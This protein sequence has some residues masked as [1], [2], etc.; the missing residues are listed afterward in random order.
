MLTW[1][2]QKE[3]MGRP[4][5]LSDCHPIV[6]R[7]HEIVLLYDLA[8]VRQWNCWMTDTRL[9]ITSQTTMA[10]LQNIFTCSALVQVMTFAL[11]Q[12]WGSW[13]HPKIGDPRIFCGFLQEMTRTPSCTIREIPTGNVSDS[14]PRCKTWM[15][16]H[17]LCCLRCPKFWTT[18]APTF[19]KLRRFTK[20]AMISYDFCW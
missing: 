2:Q 5:F 17:K 18:K 6:I 12:T 14:D 1:W 10:L 7:L 9:T 16:A 19:K 13:T 8:S 11:L 4:R 15:L 3:F 20:V